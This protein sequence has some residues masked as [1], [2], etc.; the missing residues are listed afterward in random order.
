M[1]A[2]SADASMTVTEENLEEY[3]DTFRRQRPKL[4]SGGRDRS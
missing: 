3:K 1:E 2:E 4:V